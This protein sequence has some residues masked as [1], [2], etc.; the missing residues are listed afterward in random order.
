MGNDLPEDELTESEQD[1][2]IAIRDG[3][4]VARDGEAT[5]SFSGGG[6]SGGS[7]AGS[8]G[9]R[10]VEDFDPD[11]Y[12][13]ARTVSDLGEIRRENYGLTD[14]EQRRV[15]RGEDPVGSSD[16]QSFVQYDPE[17]DGGSGEVLSRGDT[18]EEAAANRL[19][20]EL[21][22][23]ERRGREPENIQINTEN[24]PFD[25]DLSDAQR[26]RAS[27][28]RQEAET[29]QELREDLPDQ[30]RLRV[31][32]DLREELGSEIVQRQEL[33]NFLQE[34][35]EQ[36]RQ[37]AQEFE[38]NAIEQE[39]QQQRQ[40]ILQDQQEPD[41]PRRTTNFEEFTE[42]DPV[43]TVPV[44]PEQTLEQ[45]EM[46]AL[47]PEEQLDQGGFTTLGR[48]QVGGTQIQGTSVQDQRMDA[49]EQNFGPI[50]PEPGQAGASAGQTARDL[51]EI[52][53]GEA[54]LDEEQM[55]EASGGLQ[56]VQ[57]LS[58]LDTADQ[59]IETGAAL[60]IQTARTPAA[61][62]EF[63]SQVMDEGFSAVDEAIDNM[64]RLVGGSP[65]MGLTEENLS[66]SRVRTLTPD[67]EMG[68]SAQEISRDAGEAGVLL[69]AISM[70]GLT[71]APG[72]GVATVPGRTST[73]TT[74]RTG[75]RG[76]TRDRSEIPERDIPDTEQLP[77]G[78]TT[79]Q[80][81]PVTGV[82]EPMMGETS[83][84]PGLTARGRLLDE[85]FRGQTRQGTDRLQVEEGLTPTEREVLR[86]RMELDEPGVQQRRGSIERILDD[87]EDAVRDPKGQAELIPQ[88]RQRDVETRD[89]IGSERRRFEEELADV[90]TIEQPSRPGQGPASTVE[91]SLQGRLG[92][93]IAPDTMEQQ[94]FQQIQELENMQEQNVV[95]SMEQDLPIQ[96]DQITPVTQQEQE[97]LTDTS[98]QTTSTPVAPQQ[99]PENVLDRTPAQPPIQRQLRPPQRTRTRPP[100]MLPWNIPGFEDTD[101]EETSLE[102]QLIDE[103]P[104]SFPD[105]FGALGGATAEQSPDE[106]TFTGFEDRVEKELDRL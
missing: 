89:V 29:L 85:E 38:I 1:A 74:T 13:G 58:I 79:R 95:Q 102:E 101:D 63:G 49:I 103:N 82:S 31:Q 52:T 96:E 48:E 15:S 28:A 57:P 30:D 70:P 40:Q 32:D 80:D 81:E 59:Q 26:G 3:D 46:A 25:Q 77:E 12:P 17:F 22:E 23:A 9:G 34:Q 21:R 54:F 24:L 105:L 16:G 60:G 87:I 86:D 78:F 44:N 10:S 73:T 55:E 92:I 51:S 37:Q 106:E 47:G 41:V 72:M 99:S 6:S 11:N 2:D 33:E 61:T 100:R 84:A 104:Q 7:S 8:S 56:D 67:E 45:G 93:G 98:T 5:D 27:Q 88:T 53:L 71:G 65:Q 83:P 50:L 14:Q 20:R 94:E 42:F 19:N 36:R 90:G 64:D 69:S 39:R 97:M 62:L 18:R 76:F 91:T 68:R 4:V 75:G 43:T 66:P 35:A